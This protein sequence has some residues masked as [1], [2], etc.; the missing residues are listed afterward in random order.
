M[1]VLAA[2]FLAG[3][4]AGGAAAEELNIYTSRHYQSDERLYEAF[5]GRTGIQINRIEGKGDALIARIASEGANSPADLFVAADAGLLWRADQ[6]G[7]F[8]AAESEVLEQA[9][10]DRLR[11]PEGHWFGFSTRARLI[12]YD[13]A[14][15]DPAEIRSY[16]DLADPRWRGKVCIRS[17]ANIY[18]QSLLGAIIAAHGVEAAEAWAAG[19]VANFARDPQGGDTDQI[20]GVAAGQCALALANSDY[21]VRLLTSAKDRD[22]AV[23]ERVGWIFPDQGGRGTHVNVSGAGVLVHAPH[24]DAAVKFLEFL[25]SPEA[26]RHFAEANNEYPVVAGV[27]PASALAGL[28]AFKADPVNVSA[29]GEHQAEA[30]RIFDRVGWK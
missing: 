12:F 9:I 7:L 24:R 4:L 11:H 22:R 21:F 3:G 2:A 16:Q 8:Q 23:A 27:A 15:V 28:G 17:S 29:F 13:K 25:A 30:Q 20:R 10:P 18:N 26:Q 6:A 19:V 14:K 1:G 5:T